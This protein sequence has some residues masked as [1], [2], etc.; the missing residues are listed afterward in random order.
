MEKEIPEKI[1]SAWTGILRSY[2]LDPEHQPEVGKTLPDY[3]DPWKPFSKDTDDKVYWLLI[4]K[5]EMKGFRIVLQRHFNGNVSTD[6]IDMLVIHALHVWIEEGFELKNSYKVR[7]TL[8][9]ILAKMREMIGPHTI[10][11]PIIGLDLQTDTDVWFGDCCVVPGKKRN[12]IFKKM[13]NLS[14]KKYGDKIERK[15]KDSPFLLLKMEGETKYVVESAKERGEIVLDVIRFYLGSFYFDFG[16]YDKRRRI[17]ISGAFTDGAKQYIYWF[18]GD[19]ISSE[20]FVGTSQSIDIY[21]N[22]TLDKGIYEEMKKNGINIIMPHL[23]SAILPDASEISKRL[24]RAIR[25]FS[26]GTRASDISDSFLCYVIALE[27]L[28]SKGSTSKETYASY[29]SALVSRNTDTQNMIYPGFLS[30]VYNRLEKGLVQKLRN[31]ERIKQR[32]EILEA[33][34]KYLFKLRNQIA[35]GGIFDLQEYIVDLLNLETLTKNAILSFVLLNPVTFKDF[36]NWHN[37]FLNFSA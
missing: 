30:P 28:L 5:K 19:N 21:G 37:S 7:E 34:I 32:F 1:L 10:A 13:I 12:S 23:Q 27:A 33:E 24:Y 3:F 20:T 29:V 16:P 2:K 17:G 14:G 9:D 22:F 15:Q 35:H 36:R 6:A 26:K 8:V 31:V 18:K 25:W 4:K 11:L